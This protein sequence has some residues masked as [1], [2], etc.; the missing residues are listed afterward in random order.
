[1]LLAHLGEFRAARFEAVL[2]FELLAVLRGD[3]LLDVAQLAQGLVVG[4]NLFEAGAVEVVVVGEGAAELFRVF[5]VE[6]QLE[7]FLAAALVG[8]ARLDGDQAL[9]LKAQ[10]LEFFFLPVEPLQLLFA[11]P[12]LL[13]QGLDLLLQIAHLRLGGLEL[14]LYPGLLF[15]DGAE[16]LLQLGDVLLGLFELALGVATFVGDG[17]ERAQQADQQQGGEGTMHGVAGTWIRD[18]T[19][20]P[21]PAAKKKRPRP[22]GM[23][24]FPVVALP[25]DQSGR[26][27]E[28]PVIS[29]GTGRPIRVSMVGATSASTPPSRTCRLRL[30][31]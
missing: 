1:M 16:R 30:P 14:L 13:L 25:V 31:T 26:T 15:L 2:L 12:E 9:L 18:R 6:Q 21:A 19:S 20:M 29:A 7:V 28:V 27:I 11:L 17:G 22:R 4:G 10:A 24:R 3:F 5:L 8:R 23:G